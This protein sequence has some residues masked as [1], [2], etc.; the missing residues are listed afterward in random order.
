MGGPIGNKHALGCKT[1]GRPVKYTPEIKK[2]AFIDL[3]EWSKLST[4]F[5]ILKFCFDKEYDTTL[6]GIWAKEDDELA[7]AYK[8]AKERLGCNI[9]ERLH[10]KKNPYNY[11]AFQREIGMYDS[12]LHEFERDEKIF[13]AELKKK[14]ESESSK[15]IPNVTFNIPNGNSIKIQPENISNSNSG[16]SPIGD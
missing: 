7:R 9:R 16:S 2:Q 11:G 12:I 14:Y 6:L 5:N 4:S 8:K 15:Q 3:L 10:D 1:S 13:D